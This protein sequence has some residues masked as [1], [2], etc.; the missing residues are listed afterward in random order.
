MSV[1][2]KGRINMP[3]YCHSIWRTTQSYTCCNTMSLDG[4]PPRSL[5]TIHARTLLER[6]ISGMWVYRLCVRFCLGELAHA[7]LERMD[8]QLTDVGSRG[9]VR[10]SGEGQLATLRPGRWRRCRRCTATSARRQPRR[11][12]RRVVE[13]VDRERCWDDPGIRPAHPVSCASQP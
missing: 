13:G 8:R 7:A 9:P 1:I 4:H 3:C 10:A 6:G 2:H 12:I 11:L 5:W